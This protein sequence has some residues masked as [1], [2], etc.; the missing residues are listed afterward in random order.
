MPIRCDSDD[1]EEQRR[2]DAEAG[3]ETDRVST[4]RDVRFAI[5][6]APEVLRIYFNR[7]DFQGGKIREDVDYPEVIDLTQF[8]KDG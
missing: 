3:L 6:Q 2:S 4:N 1:C 7:D 5:T 8:T